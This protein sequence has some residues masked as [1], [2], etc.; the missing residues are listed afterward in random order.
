MKPFRKYIQTSTSQGAKDP[1]ILDTILVKKNLM[2]SKISVKKLDSQQMNLRSNKINNSN[3]ETIKKFN[4]SKINIKY[5]T[6]HMRNNK[7][8]YTL[9]KN[10]ERDLNHKINI[11]DAVDGN[12]I[13]LETLNLYDSNIK[14]NINFKFKGEL[15][16]YL[17]HLQLLKKI[18]N[19]TNQD[20]SIILE[21]DCS[22]LRDYV[23]LNIL[24]IL[25]Q[26]NV[27]FDIIFL[28]NMNNNNGEHYRNNIYFVNNDTKLWGTYAYLVNNKNIYKIIN[29]L[30]DI[31]NA[32]DIKFKKLIDNKEL[33]G[34]VIFP[35]LMTQANIDSTIR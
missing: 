30:Y 1:I 28:G 17:S 19:N 7:E 24:H 22:V 14:L 18:S 12:K 8:R 4:D 13:D 2:K 32:I 23:H 3:Y 5:F 16:C 21:D 6:I 27:D 33:I 26:I 15:G 20:Y 25:D 11:F 34:L 29:L 35:Q 31:D 9:I 10:L